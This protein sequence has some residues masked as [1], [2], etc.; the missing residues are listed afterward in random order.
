MN[1]PASR[2]FAVVVLAALAQAG[3]GQMQAQTPAAEVA[4]EWKVEAGFGPFSVL[5]DSAAVVATWMPVSKD[6]VIESFAA[7]YVRVSAEGRSPYA[8]MPES[9]RNPWDSTTARYRREYAR[10]TTVAIQARAIGAGGSC[11]W[12]LTGASGSPP[13]TAVVSCATWHRFEAPLSGARL[14]VVGD[15]ASGSTAVEIDHKVV[16]G[17]G[18]SYGSGEGNPDVPTE[19]RSGAAPAGSYRWLSDPGREG[20][21]IAAGAQWWDTACHRSF[22]SHQSYVAMRLAAENPHRLVTFLH[23][24]C[25]AAEVF[26]GVMVRQHEPPGMENCEGMRCFVARSQLGAAVRD[27]C[28]G[29]VVESSAPIGRIAAAVK[30]DPRLYFMKSYKQVGLDLAECSG[31]L[32]APD[33]VLLS[34]GGND[35]GFGAL[36]GWAVTP[37][38]AR[39]RVGSFLGGYALLRG[40]KVTCPERA[41]QSGCKEP[42][43]SQ[44]IR[45]LPRRFALLAPALRDLLGVTADRVVVATYP[46]PLRDRTGQMCGDPAGFRPKSP[47]AGAHSQLPA[48]WLRNLT[49]VGRNWDFNL[50]ATEAEILSKHTLRNLRGAIESAAR[51]HGFAVASGAADAFVGHCWTEQDQGDAPTALPSADPSA[52]TCAGQQAG[53]PSCWKPFAPRRR[54][55]RTINDALLTQSSVRGDDMTGA[56]HPTAQGHAAVADAVLEAVR[57]VSALKP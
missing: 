43:D 14:A 20:S 46:D 22:W 6:G 27:L 10:P 12:T 13:Q 42:F 49:G 31:R 45:Q 32:R 5:P 7:W 28:E 15:A 4:I 41:I 8:V 40:T 48:G 33:L 53:S 50:L 56:V 44:L 19:W 23:Y 51:T 39:T 11:R 3:G 17:L 2:G 1:A 29:S 30:A 24:A 26:D 38:R 37:P 57:G 21:M 16:V 55:I 47:W 54:F 18:D 25:S 9:P 34:I 35:V 36:A 52:W